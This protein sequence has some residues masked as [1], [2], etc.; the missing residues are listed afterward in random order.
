[1]S[2][3]FV[4]QR[5]DW[6]C[7]VASIAMWCNVPY[8]EILEKV[9]NAKYKAENNIGMDDY[10]AKEILS[11]YGKECISLD[12]AYGGVSGI[13]SFPSL[14]FEGGGHALFY[15]DGIIY[16]PQEGREGKRSYGVGQYNKMWPGCYS[17]LVD[18]NDPK[19]LPYARLEIGSKLAAIQ[20]AEGRE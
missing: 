12:N 10:D 9:P 4:Q 13:L 8:E 14:N 15:H 20:E 5:G 6:D 17:I 19:T 3:T 18:L 7:V 2:V 11:T 16:D 1:M